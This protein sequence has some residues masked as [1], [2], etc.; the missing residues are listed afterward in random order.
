M[1]LGFFRTSCRNGLSLVHKT[2]RKQQSLSASFFGRRV[3]ALWN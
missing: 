1:R 3:H 2:T